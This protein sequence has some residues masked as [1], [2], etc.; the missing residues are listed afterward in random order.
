MENTNFILELTRLFCDHKKKIIGAFIGL[1]TGVL[2]LVIGFWH[3]VLLLILTII[4]YNAGAKWNT[5][6]IF[7]KKLLNKIIP[8]VFK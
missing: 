7:F 3:T 8:P 1:I 5:I 6:S 2:I 4:G